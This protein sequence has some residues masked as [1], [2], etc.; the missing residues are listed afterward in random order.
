MGRVYTYDRQPEFIKPC[1]RNLAWA[2]LGKNVERR[3]LDITEG[4]LQTDADALFLDVRTPWD[5]LA[6]AAAAMAPSA[7]SFPTA[8]SQPGLG[9]TGSHGRPAIC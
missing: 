7:H 9:S 8:H 5:Y 4:F 2:G 6:Q 1:G 3:C